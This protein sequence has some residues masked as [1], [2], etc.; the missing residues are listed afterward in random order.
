MSEEDTRETPAE[1]KSERRL[2]P[3]LLT[4]EARS[5][6]RSYMLTLVA[7]PGL[8]VA[9][10]TFSLGFFV[11]EA[12]RGRA[13][14]DAYG[15]A[16]SVML[17][18]AAKAVE[19]ARNAEAAAE[20]ASILERRMEEAVEK[21]DEA[22][23][24]IESTMKSLSA[25]VASRLGTDEAFQAR[26]TGA[27]QERV[28]T[29]DQVV[30]RLGARQLLGAAPGPLPRQA[31]L[32]TQGGNLVLL[33]TGSGHGQP[34]A[35]LGMEVLLDGRVVGLV[36]SYSNEGRSHKAFVPA[37]ISLSGVPPGKHTVELRNWGGTVTDQNDFFSVVAFGAR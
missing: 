22:R 4:L 34:E 36:R 25:S 21:A 14:A 6:I 19:S 10:A 1:W 29:L 33:I 23:K 37:A 16:S 12:A 24:Q 20:N 7:L 26:V 27:L 35:L 9:A 13:Y 30:A 31:T 5:A 17:E 11:N 28:E 2:G 18:T 32:E 15:Q 3:D 8:V